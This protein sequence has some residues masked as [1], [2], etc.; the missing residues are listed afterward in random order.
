[1]QHA[2]VSE[3]NFILFIQYYTKLHLYRPTNMFKKS[4]FNEVLVDRCTICAI[5]PIST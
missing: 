1:M 4:S 5:K 2:D 3:A